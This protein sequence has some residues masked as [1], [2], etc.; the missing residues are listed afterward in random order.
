MG[1]GIFF[2]YSLL[3]LLI[4]DGTHS[5]SDSPVSTVQARVFLTGSAN[6]SGALNLT[7]MS[8]QTG[9]HFVGQVTGLTPGKHGFHVHQFGDVSTDGCTSTGA[10]YNP[11]SVLKIYY[12]QLL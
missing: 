2:T 7:E 11:I 8:N 5:A 1:A 10:H 6:V 4:V 3:T 12:S 9:V